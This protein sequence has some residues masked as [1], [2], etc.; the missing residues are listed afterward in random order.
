MKYF[1]YSALALSFVA[2]R[3]VSSTTI[4]SV[5]DN[6]GINCVTKFE[7]LGT[8]GISNKPNVLFSDMMK[9][10]KSKYG[11]EITITNIRSRHNWKALASL[12]YGHEEEVLFDVYRSV[13]SN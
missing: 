12:Q 11:G 10:A 3:Q 8:I 13:D 1:L 2:C 4:Y 5:E 9:A 6:I 7:F